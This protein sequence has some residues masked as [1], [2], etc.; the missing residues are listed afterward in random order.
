MVTVQSQVR[1]HFLQFHDVHEAVVENVF[2][3]HR[4]AFSDAVHG[5]ELSLHIRGE[6]GKRRGGYIN[7]PGFYPG[8]HCQ[9][10]ARL[11]AV[12]LGA[13]FHQ[14]FQHRLQQV[15][16]GIFQFDPAAGHGR[17]DQVGSGFYP[18]RQD[19]VAGSTQFFH[20]LYL[21]PAGSRSADFRAHAVK[22]QRQVGH[23]GFP[24]GIFDDG[25]AFCQRCGHHQVFRAGNG[26]RIEVD[27]SAMQTFSLRLYVTVVHGN[28]RA[29][30]GQSFQVQVNRPRTNGAA[31]R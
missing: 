3:N 6:I 28:L 15:G 14:L 9:G 1:A 24:C 22:A 13:G 20:A 25:S 10:Y 26:H 30:G 29:H 5:G 27:I 7:R 23:L 17:R 2:S 16:S 12:D 19:V 11:V 8:L 31:A 4:A 18:V 21:D